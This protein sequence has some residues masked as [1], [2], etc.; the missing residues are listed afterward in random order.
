MLSTF[1]IPVHKMETS[2]PLPWH[3]RAVQGQCLHQ[4][5]QDHLVPGKTLT[6]KMSHDMGSILFHCLHDLFGPG[7]LVLLRIPV[8][9]HQQQGQQLAEKNF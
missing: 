9:L 4:S 7:H 2:G 1:P 3:A 6:G 5:P 8:L